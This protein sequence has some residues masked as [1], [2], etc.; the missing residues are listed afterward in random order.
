VY[1]NAERDG[2]YLFIEPNGDAMVIH[3]GQETVIGNFLADFSGVL[4]AWRHYVDVGRLQSNAEA[5]YALGDERLISWSTTHGPPALV[6]S[7]TWQVLGT[8]AVCL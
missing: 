8:N 5:T 1:R 2:K 3:D 4:T 6:G 7:P